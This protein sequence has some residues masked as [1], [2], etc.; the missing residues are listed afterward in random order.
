M[1]YKKQL[2]D[3]LWRE[4]TLRNYAQQS[5]KRLEEMAQENAELKA[6]LES[7]KACLD[8]FNSPKIQQLEQENQRLKNIIV[9]QSTRGA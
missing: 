2:D 4:E 9:A 5:D 3:A 6:K 1:N 8:S 7:Y